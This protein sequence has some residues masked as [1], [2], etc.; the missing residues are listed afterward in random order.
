VFARVTIVF[1]AAVVAA[2]GLAA[3][4]GAVATWTAIIPALLG[5]L[6]ILLVVLDRQP[7][8]PQAARFQSSSRFPTI[9]AAA[10]V[11]DAVHQLLL[12]SDAR[13]SSSAPAAA[14][15]YLGGLVVVGIGY[16]VFGAASDI[17]EAR[18]VARAR[19]AAASALSPSRPAR[20]RRAKRARR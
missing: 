7:A 15:L 12:I 6:L 17:A 19:A 3:A 18:R 4:I 8:T 11:F 20:P 1:G 13:G 16:I 5:G 10:L 2:S 14:G 9:V